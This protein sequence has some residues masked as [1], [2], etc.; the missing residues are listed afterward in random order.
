MTKLTWFE[1]VNYG[2]IDVSMVCDEGN[3][4]RFTNN[5]DGFTNTPNICV[6]GFSLLQAKEQLGYG[7]I[8]IRMKCAGLEGDVEDANSNYNINGFWNDELSCNSG[9]VITGLEVREQLGF[10]IINVKISCEL[11]TIPGKLNFSFDLC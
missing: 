9:Y 5:E 10:G 8:N 3:T 1:Q 4:F 6:D 7:I 11:D 2:L